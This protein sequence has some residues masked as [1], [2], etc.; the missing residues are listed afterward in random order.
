MK[1]RKPCRSEA[2]QY[3]FAEIGYEYSM[4]SK[5][6]SSDERTKEEALSEIEKERR[7]EL[8]GTLI[9]EMWKVAK[10]ELNKQQFSILDCM[11]RKNMTQMETSAFINR[12]QSSVHK[13]LC[14]NLY[15]NEMNGGIFKKLRD[16]MSTNEIVIDCLRQLNGDDETEFTLEDA[17]MK[18]EEVV[19]VEVPKRKAGR[20]KKAVLIQR[21]CI[22]IYVA[23]NEYAYLLELAKASGKNMNQFI[24]STVLKKT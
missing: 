14:G 13:S 17:L 4:L 2:Y 9:A 16:V 11:Y 21:K 1:E 22:S 15:K 5:L 23:P 3:K 7:D 19:I 24:V 8:K 10:K 18:N 12:N 6:A 20:P